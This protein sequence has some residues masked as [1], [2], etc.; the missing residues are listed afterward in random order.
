MIF[1]SGQPTRVSSEGDGATLLDWVLYYNVFYKFGIAHWL[2]R[3]KKQEVIA[4]RENVIS[5]ATFHPKRQIVQFV[6]LHH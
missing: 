4:N 2:H 6:T 1:E 5:L 3:T